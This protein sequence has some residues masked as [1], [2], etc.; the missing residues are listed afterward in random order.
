MFKET[1]IVAH[2]KSSI[3][4]LVDEVKSVSLLKK[5]E[6]ELK[7]DK[8]YKKDWWDEL[9]VEQQKRISKALINANAGKN[10]VSHEAALKRIK[11]AGKKKT[12]K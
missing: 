9:P 6:K 10:M 4:A 12:V 2:L 8:S 7:E 1:Q 3:H 5:V 11:Q